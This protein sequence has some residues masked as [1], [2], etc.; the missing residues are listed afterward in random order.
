MRR[1]VA[2]VIGGIVMFVWGAL[3]HV[4]L[5]IG[6][7]GMRT[8]SQQDAALAAVQAAASD[9]PGVYLLPGM[10][11]EAWDDPAQKAAFQDKYRASAFAFMVYAPGGNAA[12]QDM[13]P[14]LAKQWASD[15]LAAALLA[16]LMTLSRFGFARRVALAGAASLFA[17]LALSVP[18]WNWYQFPLAFTLGA[19]L[20]QLPGWLLAGAAM[21]VWLGRGERRRL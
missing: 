12:A 17:W 14:N 5:P 13:G 9:G 10:A 15:T 11:P 16:W 2:A 19:L 7:L 20:E 3:A 21:A 1:I 6:T 4:A 8:A 18:Y